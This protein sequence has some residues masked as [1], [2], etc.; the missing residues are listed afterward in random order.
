MLKFTRDVEPST[1]GGEAYEFCVANFPW[2][3]DVIGVVTP[4]GDGLAFD[5][6][7]SALLESWET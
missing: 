3:D 1:G 7:Y 5:G 4:D 2:C 6:A